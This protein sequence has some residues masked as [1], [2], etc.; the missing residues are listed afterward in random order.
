M[1]TTHDEATVR[2][3]HLADGPD[4]GA[5]E[6]LCYAPLWRALELAAAQPEDIQADLFIATDNDVVAY[7]D[8]VG[9]AG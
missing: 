9:G 8:L 6:T 3:Y 7:L 4:G 1:R 5:A 2:L